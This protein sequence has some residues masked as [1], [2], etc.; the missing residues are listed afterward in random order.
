VQ[1]SVQTCIYILS[2]TCVVPVEGSNA[3]LNVCMCMYMCLC[4]CVCERVCVLFM[5]DICSVYGGVRS[6]IVCVYVYVCV[7]VCVRVC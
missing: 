6:E 7:R 1:F 4:A 3:K 2:V 5:R